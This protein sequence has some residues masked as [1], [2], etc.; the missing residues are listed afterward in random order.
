MGRTASLKY[1]DQVIELPLVEGTEGEVAVDITQLGTSLGGGVVFLTKGNADTAWSGSLDLSA[2]P[3]RGL[4][5]RF[6]V[7][8]DPGTPSGRFWA[9]ASVTNNVTQRVTIISPQ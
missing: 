4:T 3:V 2:L 1:G 8:I 6:T 9:F 7:V 5:R